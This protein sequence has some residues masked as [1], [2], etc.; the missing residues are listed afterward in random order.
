MKLISVVSPCYNEE[1]NVEALVERVRSLFAQ[2]PQY[3]YEH[4]LIDNHSTDRTVELLRGLAATDP[5]VKV[6]CNARNFGHIR[7]PQHA[8]LSATGDAVVVLL[9]DLQDPPELLFEF[10]REWEAGYPIVVGVKRTSDE[11]AMVYSVRSIYYKLIAKLTDVKVIEH[12]TGFGLYDK[13]VIEILRNDFKDPNPYLRGQ[14]AEIGLPHKEVYYNQKRRTRGITKN[15]FYTLYD[16]A[17]LGITNMSKVP[18][19]LVMLGGFL[20]AA[21]SLVLAFGYLIAK[22]I[23]WQHFQ[24]G[25]APIMVG[26]FFLGSVQLISI[27]IIGEYVG[28]IH[29]I[30]QNRPLVTERERINFD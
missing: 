26:L 12:Y 20:C 29:S 7:S 1:G 24:L 5:H 11:N 13:K 19:R 18:L 15:N 6:I 2:L 14:I 23:F 30:V 16:M 3:R 4:I 27:G 21:F 28:S 8:I 22:L 10:L 25:L 9:S 17:M